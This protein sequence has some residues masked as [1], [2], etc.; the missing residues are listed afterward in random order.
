VNVHTD[1]PE[2]VQLEGGV[3]PQGRGVG[4]LLADTFKVAWTG[5]PALG[6]AHQH[7][8]PLA[9]FNGPFTGKAN[10]PRGI[11]CR[12]EPPIMVDKHQVVS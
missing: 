9:N 5:R 6:G 7:G 3:K 8:L 11:R 10:S 4:G 1:I 12:T 2:T